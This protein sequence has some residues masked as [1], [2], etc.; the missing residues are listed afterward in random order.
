M[1]PFDRLLP[2]LFISTK[3]PELNR[4]QFD[5]SS[6]QIPLL[7]LILLTN[8]TA[9]AITH[10]YVAPAG[11]SLYIPLALGLVCVARLLRWL[12]IDRSIL[13]DLEV[14]R[15]L[16]LTTWLV[17]GLGIAF[18][19]WGLALYPYGDAYERVH[20]A[21]YM[22]I[23]VIGCIFCLMHVRTAPLL[24]TMIVIVPLTVFFLLTQKH[25]SDCDI[26][27]C[28][29]R[30][31]RDGLDPADVLPG[32][33]KSRQFQ[34]DTSDDPTRNPRAERRK[35]PSCQHRQPDAFAQS[36]AV[37]CGRLKR[38]D[39]KCKGYRPQHRGRSD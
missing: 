30:V 29:S 15:E 33:C 26:D 8:S 1:D 18:T 4:S 12:R 10:F 34:T 36:Q 38:T 22:S 17:M 5:A 14:A 9:L 31:N 19:S 3:N 37:L 28:S 32:F 35:P 7:Y 13:E 24:L 11:L 6:R 27:Q 25:G 2:H 21:F 20:V 23:T 16:R 39:H